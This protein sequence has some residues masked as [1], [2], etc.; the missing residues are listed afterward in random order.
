VSNALVNPSLYRP[1]RGPGLAAALSILTLA[2]ASSCRCAQTAAQKPAASATAKKHNASP[3]SKKKVWAAPHIKWGDPDLQGVWEGFE[4][5]PLE[6]PAALGDKK[7]YTDAE[8]ADR[9]AKAEARAKQRDALIA[10]G[11]V[12]HEGFRAVPNYNAIFEYSE[13]KGA[14]H[15]SNRT[16]AIIDPPDGRI[17]PWTLEQVKYWEEREALTKGRGETDTLDDLNL[18]TRCISVVNEAEITNWGL[19]FGGANSTAPGRPDAPVVGEDVDLGDGFG[20]NASPGPVRQILQSPGYVAFVM[21]ETP[22]YRIVPLNGSPHPGA[23]IR[24]WMGDARGHWE[25]DTLVVDITNITFGSPIIPNFGGALY[26]GSGET[27]HV[28]ERFRRTADDRLEFTYTIDDP[29]VYV[30]PYTVQHI[31]RKDDAREE[32]TT[33][34]QEDPKDRANS[35]AN[36]RADEQSSLDSGE[37]SVEARKARF[38]QLKQQ[39]IAWANRQATSPSKTTSR[40]ET[41]APDETTPDKTATGAKTTS[42]VKTTSPGKASRGGSH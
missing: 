30:R 18:G 37:V 20:T 6:R 28:V 34:C 21:G 24:E 4:S 9:V 35:L 7:F 22:V 11:K 29:H 38:E 13:S 12:E 5:I 8:I 17:P 32:A 14:P 33:V 1:R 19:A 10:Q 36:A 31:L 25:G 2:F 3:P 23:E 40:D 27:L 41:T 42:S 39:A 26:P 15:F 16:S